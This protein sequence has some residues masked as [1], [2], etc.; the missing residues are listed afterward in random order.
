MSKM[1]GKMALAAGTSRNIVRPS[2]FALAATGAEV[3]IQH[4]GD[5]HW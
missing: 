5:A 2:V 4:R 1:Y 3:L